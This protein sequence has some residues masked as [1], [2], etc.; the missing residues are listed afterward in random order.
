MSSLPAEE[1][2]DLEIDAPAKINFYLRVLDKRADGYHE[3]DSLMIK[4]EFADR[5]VMRRRHQAGIEV[6]CPGSDLPAGPGNLVYRAA[7]A[8]FNHCGLT[9]ALAIMLDK[10]IPVAAGLGGGSS[11]AAAVLLGLD[12]LYN[13][14]LGEQTLLDLARP[15]GADVPFFVQ[16]SPAARARGIGE[17]LTPVGVPDGVNWI[18]L[19]NPGF[20]VSTKWVYDNFRLTKQ[21]DP[22]ILTGSSASSEMTSVE[23]PGNDL[24]T[25]TMAG[26]PELAAIR[27]QLLAAGAEMALMS[28][29]GP[30]MFAVFADE[31]PARG[32]AHR[33]ARQYRQVYVTRPA[34]RT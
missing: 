20:G 30:T 29:S 28:G 7:E 32:C 15:L 4:L 10:R 33:M 18:V 13:T 2:A 11:D 22:Y 27:E 14:S 24:Q 9:P 6:Q 17:L 8:F 25:V 19:V 3:L 26:Y 23:Q 21:S 5:L 34:T 16:P 1:Q 31:Q 12:R